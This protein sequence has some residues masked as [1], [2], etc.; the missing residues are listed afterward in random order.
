MPLASVAVETVLLALKI[1]FIVLLYLFIWRIVRAAS[2]ELR[3]PQE[4]FILAPGL[5][6]RAARRRRRRS[7]R[8]RSSSCGAPSSTSRRA[9]SSTP[10]R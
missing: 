3:V 8:A 9:S 6:P 10:A 5:D 7:T 1:A 4:S 2:H